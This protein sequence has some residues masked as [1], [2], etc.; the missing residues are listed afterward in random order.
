M[1]VNDIQWGLGSATLYSSSGAT[2]TP[3]WGLGAILI[4]H[5]FIAAAG[6][7]PRSGFSF[8]GCMPVTVKIEGGKEMT[9]RKIVPVIEKQ[10]ID[11]FMDVLAVSATH[12]RSNEDLSE[13]IPNTF[14]ID[15]QPDVPRTLSGHFDSHAQITEYTIV[16]TGVDAKGNT[17]TETFTESASPW[18][19]ETVNAYATITSIIMTARTGTGDGDTMDIGITDVL[20]LSNVIATGDVYKIKKDNAP[21]VVAAEQ[22]NTTYDT[23][24]MSV[25]GLIA[26][27]DFSIWFITD[28]NIIT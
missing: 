14:S 13:A 28:L 16:I 6:R 1:S 27:N 24:D 2:I 15:A 26:R 12:V 20:G 10:F 7:I 9:E 22:V 21:A 18:D 3:R 25:I 5:E 19:F 23:Y 4:K 11:L 17:V 8:L